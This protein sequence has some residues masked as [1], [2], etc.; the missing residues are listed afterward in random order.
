MG[1]LFLS[2]KF[3]RIPLNLAVSFE[4]V[5]NTTF[6]KSKLQSRV[7][8]FAW[9]RSEWGNMKGTVFLLQM[10]FLQTLLGF[11]TFISYRDVKTH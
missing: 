3:N 9:S 8:R 4:I 11:L 10:L 2:L 7:Y 5:L 6:K 1:P